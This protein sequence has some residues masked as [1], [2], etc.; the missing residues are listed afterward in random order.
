MGVIFTILSNPCLNLFIAHELR[1]PLH[2]VIGWIDL[3]G[4]T[5]LNEEQGGFLS[6]M[7]ASAMHFMAIINDMLDF[8]KFEAGILQLEEIPFE[9]HD[10][11]EGSMAAIRGGAQAKHIKLHSDIECSLGKVVVGD[12]NRFRQ[13]LLNLLSNAVKFT[14]QDGSII[15]R[16]KPLC[17]CTRKARVRFE[18]IDTGIGISLEDQQ[19]IFT[20][21][22][23]ADA[24]VSRNYGGTGLGLA[25]CKQLCSAMGGNIGV[26]SE[27]GVG[28]TFWFE[29]TFSVVT[30]PPK[31]TPKL[32]RRKKAEAAIMAERSKCF[33][34]LVVE[35]NVVNQKVVCGMLRRMGHKYSICEN[36][37]LAVDLVT[38]SGQQIFDVILM[39]IQ[40]PVM[41]GVEATRLIRQA[42]LTLPILG[43]T[44]EIRA[45]D[46]D[47]GMTACLSK[48]IR[49]PELKRALSDVV[50]S[51]SPILIPEH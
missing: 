38:T 26:T 24:S 25:I 8:T 14:P 51:E 17:Q 16:A 13:I 18:I 27:V 48:P 5:K 31:G 15:L 4:Q 49:L 36:G 28:S 1:T 40:M 47:I 41:D 32:S 34:V 22:Q 50:E 45:K 19:K 30:E 35:D 6:L 3:L 46:E 43:L 33:N 37:K 2:Q 10:V 9:P 7:E 29:L 12:P 39:D 11:L 23:Q 42:G 21:F 44:A 20:R